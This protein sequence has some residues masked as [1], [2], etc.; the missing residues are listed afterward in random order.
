MRTA[1][2]ALKVV[3]SSS[4]TVVAVY[5][6]LVV[7][8]GLSKYSSEA[9]LMEIY[10]ATGTY[11]AALAAAIC[12]ICGVIVGIAIWLPRFRRACTISIIATAALAWLAFAIQ[13]QHFSHCSTELYF[14]CIDN[15]WLMK[16]RYLY[17]ALAITALMVLA[18]FVMML[19]RRSSRLTE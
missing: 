9:V 13:P 4:T 5:L 1:H 12:A 7:V 3:C 10:S 19:D 17:S 16:F 15:F 14:L 2:V 11:L 18:G 6:L 8:T